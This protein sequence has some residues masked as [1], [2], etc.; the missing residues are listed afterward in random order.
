MKELQDNGYIAVF[1]GG[2]VRDT[3]LNLDPKD[4]DIATNANIVSVI[5]VF[6]QERVNPVGKAFGVYLVDSHE[7]AT[8]RTEDG[9][10]DGRH[11]DNVT[12]VMTMAEDSKRRDFTINAMYYD[13]II[14]Q[15]YDFHNGK[16][17]LYHGVIRFVGNPMARIEEDYIR[18]LRAIRFAVRFNF[19]INPESCMAILGN[20]NLI[21]NAAPERVGV[22]INKM[23]EQV[24]KE[25]GK[26]LFYLFSSKL[27]SFLIPEIETMRGCEQPP[28]FHPEGDVFKH[29]QLVLDNLPEDASNELCWAALLHDIGKPEVQKWDDEDK[30]WRFN[31]HDAAS[32]RLARTIL[33]RFKFSNDFIDQ[34]CELVANHMKFMHVS[35]LKEA[36]LKRFLSLPNFQWHLDLHR[37]DCLGSHGGLENITFCQEKIKEFAGEAQEVILPKNI[38]NGHDLMARGI[39]SGP[40]LKPLL[41]RAFDMQLEG[42]TREEILNEICPVISA[43]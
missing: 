39:P 42:K 1:A 11:P 14:D 6:G 31:S 32:E 28:Q 20:A 41:E 5:Q 27:V 22:E 30:R 3:L 17:D 16:E 13:P 38:V 7:I 18:L 10:T 35:S 19:K 23:F 43:G 12:F 25:K 33:T 9:Y 21:I 4:F 29:T 34:V 40:A 15:W 2:C 36:K 8:F 37:A 26:I 24:P